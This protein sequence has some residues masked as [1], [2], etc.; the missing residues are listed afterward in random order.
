MSR[1]QVGGLAL[2]I[3]DKFEDNVGLVVTLNS[4]KGYQDSYNGFAYNDGWRV[5][6]VNQKLQAMCPKTGVVKVI[7]EAITSA[8]NLM[9]LGDE[10]SKKQFEKEKELE[11][12]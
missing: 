6:G 12:T 7:D 10:E 8:K 1:L 2:V 11:N 5:S 9:P 3:A 4:F